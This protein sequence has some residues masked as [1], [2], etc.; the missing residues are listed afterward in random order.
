MKICGYFG[1][2]NA[3]A[4]A[5]I[6]VTPYQSI[7][8]ESTRDALGLSLNSNYIYI[9]LNSLNIDKVLVFDEGHNIMETIC[10]LN[11]VTISFSQLSVS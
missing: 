1:S 11:T 4:E 8:S 9:Y 7:L 6:I 10:S 2:R 3:V 5:D